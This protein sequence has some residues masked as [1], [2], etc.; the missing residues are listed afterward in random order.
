M[1]E[2]LLNTIID[3]LNNIFSGIFNVV[4]DFVIF[5]INLIFI[6]IDSL[7]L[8]V[9][10]NFKDFISSINDFMLYALNYAGWILDSLGIEHFTIIFL[11]DCLIFKLT[12]P[13]GVYFT[14]LA[15]SWYNHLKT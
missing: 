2:S 11:V 3:I 1:I 5:I 7:L 14:K 6:P 15:I 8:S 12:V 9:M 13:L 4:L 10:P